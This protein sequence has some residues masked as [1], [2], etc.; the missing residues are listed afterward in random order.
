MKT[1]AL[2]RFFAVLLACAGFAAALPAD[3]DAFRNGPEGLRYRDLQPGQGAAA[4]TGQVATI[5]LV[6]W[7][8]DQGARG[9]ELY[10]TRRQRGKPLSFVIGSDRVMPAWNLGVLGM[11]QGGQRMLLVPPGLAYGDRAVDGVVPAN[12]S[13]MLRIDLV[14]L[15]D[16]PDP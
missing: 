6:G 12:A 16:L 3:D 7:V 1:A 15:E 9:R 8:D 11:K 4:V 10:N 5:H 14:G 13:L 2:T